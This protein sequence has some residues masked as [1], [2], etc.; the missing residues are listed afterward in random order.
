MWG[1]ITVLL[2]YELYRRFGDMRML[3]EAYPAAKAYPR[4]SDP[5]PTPI[6]HLSSPLTYRHLSN[7]HLTPI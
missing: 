5:Y 2:P 6:R 3:R 4:S 7:I 1:G